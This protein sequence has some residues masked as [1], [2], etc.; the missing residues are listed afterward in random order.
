MKAEIYSE[1]IND[2]QAK[3]LK[4][5]REHRGHINEEIEDV[6]RRLSEA[7]MTAR[8]NADEAHFRKW[9]NLLLSA[10]AA[11]IRYELFR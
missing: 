6:S 1:L 10:D 8:I 5:K 2:M 9:D 3:I 4:F 7:R 11:M